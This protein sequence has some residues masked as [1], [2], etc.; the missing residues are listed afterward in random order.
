MVRPRRHDNSMGHRHRKLFRQW[1]LDWLCV[2]QLLLDIRRSKNGYNSGNTHVI[3]IHTDIIY[4]FIIRVV[5]RWV[6]FTCINISYQYVFLCHQLFITFTSIQAID[7][8]N[9]RTDKSRPII[10]FFHVRYISSEWMLEYN[11]ER[12]K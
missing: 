7:R 1:M 6:T 8:Q 12:R 5:F 3:L 11:R 4:I 2:D 9:M 10:I